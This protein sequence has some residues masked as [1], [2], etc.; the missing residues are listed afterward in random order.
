MNIK[1]Q[2]EFDD[3]LAIA[4]QRIWWIVIPA[5]LVPAIVFAVCLKLP[6]RYTSQTLVLVETQKVPDSLVKPVVT[7]PLEE[8]LATMQE[9]ILSRTRLQPI[10][11][12]FGLYK[13]EA[14]NAPM[15]DL[16]DRMRKAI[17]VT[18]IKTESNRANEPMPGFYVAFTAS[19]PRLAQ[20]VCGEIT[21]LFMTENLRARE[22]SA[23]GTTDF[24]RS[25][26]DDSKRLLDEKDAKLAAFKQQHMGQLP[27]ESQ[28]NLSMMSGLETQLLTSNESLNRLVQEKTYTESLL[29][30]QTAVRNAGGGSAQA[31]DQETQRAK[32]ETELADLRSRYTEDHPD[33]AKAKAA[34]AALDRQAKKPAA[35]K[36]EASEAA[37]Q[38]SSDLAFA[39]LKAR[40][41]SLNGAI[42]DNKREQ[43]RI[44]RSMNEVSQRIRMSPAVE[45]QYKS[46]TR[47]Y[48]TAL[49]NYNDLLNKKNQSEMATD[50][51]RRQQG[52]QFRVMDPPNL[53]EH[54]T[55]PDI[56]LFTGVGFAGGLGLGFVFAFSLSTLDQ[57]L[58]SEKDVE[59]YLKLHTLVTIPDLTDRRSLD[60]QRISGNKRD[61]AAR[62]ARAAR[63]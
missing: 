51:E 17:V 41:K 32:L 59:F 14:S 24:L 61:S 30:Q 60:R 31:N 38:A 27:D 10:I 23:Q 42:E 15:E 8:R 7:E 37:S 46:I 39:P 53:P 62:P 12:R 58:K 40:L 5:V 20:T 50:L 2:L 36:T 19:D 22:Q 54:P 1:R 63:G 35:E 25:Q 44:K 18:P 26:L 43:E 13:N 45:E 11:E 33:V 52:E 49:N 56:P 28:I 48:Q 47:D 21:S 34:L 57:S 6:K 3:Y 16:V 4:R 55:F 9:Q 29:G